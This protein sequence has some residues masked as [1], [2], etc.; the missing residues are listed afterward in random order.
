[1][2]GPFMTVMQGSGV[3]GTCNLYYN[4][5]LD[6]G[7]ILSVCDS[8]C[9]W[10]CLFVCYRNHFLAVQFQNLANIRNHHDLAEVLKTMGRRRRL[11]LGAPQTP[12]IIIFNLFCRHRRRRSSR[13][14]EK[15][16]RWRVFREYMWIHYKYVTNVYDAQL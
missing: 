5:V 8:V 15:S 6:V 4:T 2:R 1:M 11:K 3:S 12:Q 9:L 16:H 13:G 14:R 10:F 7:M